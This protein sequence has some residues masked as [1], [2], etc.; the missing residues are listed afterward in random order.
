VWAAGRDLE[1]GRIREVAASAG[2][3]AAVCVVHGMDGIGK[4]ALAL[5]A[6]HALADAF[7]DGQLFIDLCGHTPGRQPLDAGTALDRLLRAVGVPGEQVPADE[8]ERA[9][10][11]RARLA[12]R[13]V[14]VVLD[15][16]AGAAQ[17]R[18][19]LPGSAGCL[20]LVT[21][22]YRVTGLDGTHVIS[23]DPLPAAEGVRLVTA[24]VGQPAVA[25]DPDA[26]LELTRL[27]GAMPLAIRL[28]AA[29]LV[30][31]PHRTLRWLADRLRD[32]DRRLDYLT[33]EDRGV[34][35]SLALSYRE[36]G[37][38][39]RRLFRMLGVAP[40]EWCRSRGRLPPHRTS[41]P[42]R[43]RPGGWTRSGATW[44]RRSRTP[45]I[46]GDRAT[47]GGSPGASGP[48]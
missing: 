45:R 41:A 35:A 16:A 17:V 12:G 7:P 28:A 40:G 11:W 33:G 18:P 15:N 38:R 32:E 44:W 10:L 39:E 22:R 21:S 30:D 43:M 31:R 24:I 23:L 47:R 20:A 29:R 8:D 34:E 9:A 5:H 14:L 13:R 4:T 27:C 46:T 6:A 19:L 25:V 26:A 42:R 3:T 48:G 36:L 1:L 37:D 2:A